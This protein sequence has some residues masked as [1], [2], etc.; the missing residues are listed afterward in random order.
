MLKKTINYFMLRSVFAILLGVLLI[1]MPENIISLI[2]IAVGILFIIPGIIT[3]VGYFS[4]SKEQR[5]DLP[6]LFAGVGCLLFGILLVI[7]PNFFEKILMIL[8]GIVLLI[9][10][11][12]QIVSLIRARKMIHVNIPVYFYIVPLLI[13]IV[14]IIALFRPF[15]TSHFIVVVIGI[16]CVIYG[17]MEF[18]FW[19]KFRREVVHSD[20]KLLEEDLN[21]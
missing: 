17:I 5:P 7:L 4:S 13:M 12:E 18:V 3:L 20:V 9:G 8:L 21:E 14:G 1:T 2:V 10:A 19:I 16:S 11:T 6:V 15:E